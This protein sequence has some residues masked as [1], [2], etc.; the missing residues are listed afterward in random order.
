[1]NRTARAR[2]VTLLSF[3]LTLAVS[4]VSLAGTA[5]ADT[6]ASWDDPPETDKLQLLLLLVGVPLL[7]FV[8]IGLAVY[9]PAM[10]RGERIAPGATS[11][12]NEWLGG[13]RRSAGELADPDTHDSEAGG[14]S[15]R[16]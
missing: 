16:W 1:V 14:A 3:L 6:P 2:L 10:V 13:P 15:G 9:L 12:Q 8:L 5:A 4:T 11:P 7:L